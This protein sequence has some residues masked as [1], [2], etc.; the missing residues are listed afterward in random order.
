M[1][2]GDQR[3]LQWWQEEWCP[4][5]WV[6]ESH[7]VLS[8]RRKRTESWR[9]QEVSH[10]KLLRKL[11]FI[12]FLLFTQSKG[13]RDTENLIQ[14]SIKLVVDPKNQFQFHYITEQHYCKNCH[15]HNMIF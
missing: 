15:G 3:P 5:P 12:Q 14:H 4:V 8:R 10:R 11:A 7:S 2:R 1:V 9:Q 13:G 6:Y